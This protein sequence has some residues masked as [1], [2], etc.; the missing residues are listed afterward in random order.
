MEHLFQMNK[1]SIYLKV[2]DL[3]V[4]GEAF[5]LIQNS[6]YGF[7]ETTPQPTSDKLPE[8]YKSEDYISHTDSQ[9]NL[10]EK[11]YH[12]VRSISLKKKLKL[13]NSF[14]LEATNLLDVGC[15]TG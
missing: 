2:K 13:I 11:A 4:S 7:L 6:E 1:K 14:Q 3:S 8:Y 12:L 15:G 5:E 10:F 9:R